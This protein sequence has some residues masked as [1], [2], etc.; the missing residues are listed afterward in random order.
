M[1]ELE[2]K[3]FVFVGEVMALDLI[4]TVKIVRG[5]KQDLL[6]TPVDL[7]DWWDIA[8]Q[9]HPEMDM[10]QAAPPAFDTRLVESVKELRD[11]LR[12]LFIRVIEGPAL[13]NA[14]VGFLNAILR[15]V[16]PVVEW[17]ANDAPHMH[18]VHDDPAA[19]VPVSVALSALHMLTSADLS[20]LRR[21]HNNR[22][23]LLFYDTTKSAT[24]QWC[25]TAC[26]E[27]ERSARRYEEKK[28]LSES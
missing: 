26:L 9:H 7:A 18:Y 15:G 19:H 6:Q 16:H 27:R 14:D 12:Q 22:C 1:N 25:S 8:R 20:R 23:I 10:S 3:G 28:R 4:N 17:P 13:S 5:K 24:R 21:C 2:E 11:Q